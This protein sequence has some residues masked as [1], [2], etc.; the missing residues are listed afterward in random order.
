MVTNLLLLILM[1]KVQCLLN[2]HKAYNL[3]GKTPKKS[4][5]K[6]LYA[7]WLQN[8]TRLILIHTS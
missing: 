1:F 8:D 5:K 3:P 4:S 2:L 7:L 6:K